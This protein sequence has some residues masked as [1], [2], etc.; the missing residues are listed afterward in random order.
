MIAVRET[1]D[2]RHFPHVSHV[3]CGMRSKEI[4]CPLNID[5]LFV[6]RDDTVVVILLSICRV[7]SLYSYMNIWYEILPLLSA[8]CFLRPLQV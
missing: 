3:Y 2:I 7:P 4:E 1:R 6:I 8:G 5:V